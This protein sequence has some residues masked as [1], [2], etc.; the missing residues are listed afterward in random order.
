MLILTTFSLIPW[1]SLAASL[2]GWACAEPE[3]VAAWR[4]VAGLAAVTVLLEQSVMLRFYRLVRGGPAWSAGYVVGACICWGMLAN[5]ILKRVGATGTT[6]RGTTYQR[7]QLAPD[8]VE[9]PA[10]CAPG[11]AA[12]EFGA[13][14]R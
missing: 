10:A 9:A 7:H 12:E 5:A 1:A 8:K 11:P 13:D 6:W 4:W 2:I 3:T 14:A